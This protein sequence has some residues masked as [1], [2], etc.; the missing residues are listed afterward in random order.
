MDMGMKG[1]IYVCMYADGV[2]GRR[3]VYINAQDDSK[4]SRL[5]VLCCLLARCVLLFV[6]ILYHSCALASLLQL[7][8]D[9][10]PFT[11]IHP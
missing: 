2:I 5:H 8:I 1:C 4:D 6:A 10:L 7:A 11:A 3:F 9:T